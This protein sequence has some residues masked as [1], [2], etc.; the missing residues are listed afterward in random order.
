L[1]PTRLLECT[2][3]AKR[4]TPGAYR[5]SNPRNLRVIEEEMSLAGVP[6][7]P[8]E[9]NGQLERDI[10]AAAADYDF[11]I[12]MTWLAQEQT[13]IKE[14]AEAAAETHEDT[15]PRVRAVLKAEA[16]RLAKK[17]GGEAG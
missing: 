14:G 17:H 7:A 12:S 6:R 1:I 10:A 16:A 2:L 4:E 3:I 11:Q 13:D 9:P 8:E 15:F 5:V